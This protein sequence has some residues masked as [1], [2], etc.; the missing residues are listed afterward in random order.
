MTTLRFFFF[1]C[2]LATA[3]PADAQEEAAAYRVADVVADV[4]AASAAV[5]REQAIMQAQRLAFQTLLERLGA[6]AQQAKA[7]DDALAALVQAFEIKKEHAAGLRYVGS[8]SVQFKPQ[9]VRQ[10]LDALGV[11]YT[12][13]RARPFVVLPVMKSATRTVMWEDRTPWHDAWAQ[14]DNNAGLV[15]FIVPTGD[16]GDIAL[17]SPAEAL[18]GKAESLAALMEKYQASGVVVALWETQGGEGDEKGAAEGTMRLYDETGAGVETTTATAPSGRLEWLSATQRDAA[19]AKTVK[20]QKESVESHWR[21]SNDIP[22]GHAVRL[23]VDVA[24]PTLAAW[25]RVQKKIL[26]LSGVSA[27]QVVS[28]TRGLVHIELAYKGAWQTVQSDAAARGLF[29]EQGANGG[30]L[31][32]EATEEQAP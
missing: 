23:P 16:L 30:W 2:L 12:E 15:P 9:A 14:S 6:T 20:T 7:S 24:V 25:T 28:M 4:T 32:R 27:A 11:G 8:F 26:S 29:F 17:I 5:A 21:A 31:L 10:W 1:L 13:N 18:A 19:M 22:S 3:L